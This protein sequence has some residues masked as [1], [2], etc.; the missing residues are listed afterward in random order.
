M[1][2]YQNHDS[3]CSSQTIYTII[4]SQLQPA[5]F[6]LKFVK[7]NKNKTKKTHHLFSQVT[8]LFLGSFIGLSANRKGEIKTSTCMTV[9]LACLRCFQE[10][11]FNWNGISFIPS[12]PAA[13][14]THINGLQSHNLPYLKGSR[15]LFPEFYFL[16]KNT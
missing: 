4:L 12:L 14:H 8:C 11:L 7:K 3:L 13:L 9:I 16:K 2:S 15:P 5:S 1:V 10:S 6:H